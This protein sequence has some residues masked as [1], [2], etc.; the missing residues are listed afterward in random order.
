MVTEVPLASRVNPELQVSHETPANTAKVILPT[1]FGGRIRLGLHTDT[2]LSLLGIFH[3][4]EGFSNASLKV[5]G[6]ILTPDQSLLLNSNP[7]YNFF[8]RG[9]LVRVQGPYQEPDLTFIMPRDIDLGE[10][11]ARSMLGQSF[12]P[13][14]LSRKLGYR[15]GFYDVSKLRWTQGEVTLSQLLDL[16]GGCN[17]FRIGSDTL[18][19]AD[20]EAI[21]DQIWR[22]LAEMDSETAIVQGSLLKNSQTFKIKENKMVGTFFE[23]SNLNYPKDTRKNFFQIKENSAYYGIPNPRILGD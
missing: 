21:S 14:T 18:S 11:Q 8:M 13:S 17:E 4:L 3:S 22:R 19:T 20:L 12:S 16:F 15:I 6:R 9:R 23:K 1:L 10:D 5:E 2:T 7:V